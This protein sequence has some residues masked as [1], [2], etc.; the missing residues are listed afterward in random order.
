M[1]SRPSIAARERQVAAPFQTF[2]GNTRVNYLDDRCRPHAS[3][4]EFMLVGQEGTESR[5]L[6]AGWGSAAT[7]AFMAFSIHSSID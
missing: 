3:H 5:R 6:V 4:K 1:H 7:E 2:A